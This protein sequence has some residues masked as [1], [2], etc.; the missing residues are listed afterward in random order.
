MSSL[1]DEY[2]FIQVQLERTLIKMKSAYKVVPTE[3]LKK[4]IK[5][6]QEAIKK[7]NEQ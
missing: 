6:L 7:I 4:K 1:E 5:L 2:E 3:K